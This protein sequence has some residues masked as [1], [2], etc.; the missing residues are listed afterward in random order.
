[1]T[2]I[3]YKYEQEY[4]KK[5]MCQITECLVLFLKLIQNLFDFITHYYFFVIN[6]KPKISCLKLNNWN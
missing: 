1:M 4:Q 5:T 6:P 2:S 3:I